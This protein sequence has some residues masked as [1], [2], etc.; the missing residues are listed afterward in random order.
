[1]ASSIPFHVDVRTQYLPEQSRPAQGLYR[2]AYTIRIT[3]SGPQAGQVIARHWW[4][5][6]GD[7][8]TEQVRGLGV[9]GAQPLL[10][11]GETFEYTSACQLRTPTGAM[12]GHYL[13]VTEEGQVFESPIAEFTL[14]AYA[15]ERPDAALARELSLPPGPRVLH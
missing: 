11:P 10:K 1:M 14:D 12:R 15:R 13:C 2:F 6:H 5:R 9:V 8:Q 4:I 7:G 3:N